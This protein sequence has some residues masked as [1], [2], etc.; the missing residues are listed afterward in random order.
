M[1]FLGISFF[2]CSLSPCAAASLLLL[3]L[4]CLDSDNNN[5]VNKHTQPFS[6]MLHYN[7]SYNNK[8]P[9][10]QW[11]IEENTKKIVTEQNGEK[12]EQQK[13]INGNGNLLKLQQR[14]HKT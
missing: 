8:P 3:F 13:N 9:K 2:V 12:E 4:L 11:V 6:E 5:N 7:M 1:Y 14:R 10:F